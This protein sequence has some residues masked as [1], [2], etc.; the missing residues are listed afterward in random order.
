MSASVVMRLD[1]KIDFENIFSWIKNN[2]DEEATML[3]Y[4]KYY[5]NG[6]EISTLIKEKYD[7]EPSYT[8]SNFINFTYKNQ[9]MN[10][11]VFYSNINTY[12]NLEYYTEYRLDNMVKSETT[13]LNMYCNNESQEVAQK[14]ISAYGGW[15]DYNDCD[16]EPFVRV[17][18]GSEVH[19]KIRHVTL[20]DIYNAFGEI[21]IIDR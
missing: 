3:P 12:D 16:E 13:S 2:I 11:F 10:L 20:Q 8:I 4:K 15:I 17:D 5:F 1:G 9:K 7:D 21:V 18:K 19:K 14:I 6:S